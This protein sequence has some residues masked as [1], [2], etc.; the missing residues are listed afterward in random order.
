MLVRQRLR[1]PRLALVLAVSVASLGV[2]LP[3]TAG[4]EGPLDD[5][6]GDGGISRVAASSGNDWGKAI[7][8]QANGRYVV[9]GYAMAHDEDGLLAMRFREDGTLDESFGVDGMARADLP[10]AASFPSDE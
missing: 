6:F 9:A 2:G 1:R 5:S 7:A 3:A 8:Q 10:N 4:E